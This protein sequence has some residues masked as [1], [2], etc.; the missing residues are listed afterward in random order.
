[1]RLVRELGG[2]F[3]GIGSSNV[4]TRKTAIWARVTESSGQYGRG[5]REQPLQCRLHT[6]SRSNSRASSYLSY[7][8]QFPLTAIHPRSSAP[9]RKATSGGPEESVFRSRNWAVTEL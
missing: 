1:M 5:S 3:Y 8:S 6:A 7:P 4:L 9:K 2:R